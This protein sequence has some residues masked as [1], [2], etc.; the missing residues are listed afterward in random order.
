MK[1]ILELLNKYF[2]STIN[3]MKIGDLK[4]ETKCA[5]NNERYDNLTIME[6]LGVYKIEKMYNPSGCYPITYVD[7]M[8]CAKK[9]GLIAM[10]ISFCKLNEEIKNEELKELHSNNTYHSIMLKRLKT[11]R[12][13]IEEVLK[14]NKVIPLNIE[15]S[16][17]INVLF[18][19]EINKNAKTK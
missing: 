18:D 17:A 3:V 1:E 10:F 9:E 6:F 19:A 2:A 8:D 16:E 13:Q 5:N 11:T 12:N 4:R 7:Y 14:I 15:F